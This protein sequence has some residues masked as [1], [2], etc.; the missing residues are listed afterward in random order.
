MLLEKPDVASANWDKSTKSKRI[1]VVDDE[2]DI[3]FVFE[4]G[5][6]KSGF[7]IQAYTSSQE[8]LED[9]KPNCFDVLILDIRMPIMDGFELYQR[10]R[11]I[12]PKVPVAFFTAFE[13][14]S[15]VYEKTIAA[16]DSN[17][18]FVKKPVPSSKLIELVN[19]I[20]DSSHC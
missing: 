11:K 1:M 18:Y 9:F 17:T 3:L 10:I 12:D 16:V 4:V 20:V 6:R 5:F 19:N 2:P 13:T 7:A 15:K 14:S 8:A